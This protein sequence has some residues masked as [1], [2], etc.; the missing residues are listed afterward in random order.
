MVY[1]PYNPPV[2][3]QQV[4][5]LKPRGLYTWPNPLSAVPQGALIEALNIVQRRPSV[6]EQRRGI[7][8][9]GTTLSDVD[10]LYTYQNHI[11][12]HHG[13]TFSYDSDDVGTWL[14]YSGSF[15]PPSNALVNRSFQANQNIYW[16]TSTGVKKLDKLTNSIT[17]SGA[18]AGLD[19]SGTTT[20]SG[21]FANTTQVAYRILFVI[22][23]ANGNRVAGAPTQR[24]IVSNNTGG[25]TNVALTFTVPTGLSTSW[26]YEIYRS[27]MSVDLNTEPNDECALVLTNNL[28]SAELSSLVVT[29]TD[30][31]PDTLK[32]AF[33][34]TAASQEGIAQANYQAPIATDAAYFKGFVFLANLTYQQQLDLT[35]VS[36][37]SLGLQN[38]DTVTIA[39]TVYTGA[40]TEVIASA[41][42]QVFTGGTPSQNITNTAN[43]LVRVINRF[44][45]NSSV[46]AYYQSGYNSLPGQILISERGIGGST[47][48]AASSRPGAFVPDIGTTTATSSSQSAPNEVAICKYLQPESFPIGQTIPVGSK[49]KS[50]LRIIALRDYV[51]VFK[52]DGVFQI[53]G[54]DV[55]SFQ[56]QEVDRTVILQGIE[57]AVALNNKVYLF[58]NQTVISITF[59]EGAI[60]KAQPIKKDLLVLSSP[61]YPAFFTVSYG[62]SYESENEYILGTVTKTTDTTATQYYVYNYLTD[63]WSTWEFPFTMGTGYVNPT[64]NKLYFGSSDMGSQFVY[65]ERKNFDE[66]D[67]ADNSYPVNITGSS[68][69]GTTYTVNLT[70][71]ATTQVGYTLAQS[72]NKAIVLSVVNSTTITVDTNIAWT[73]GA[74][75]VYKPIV[76]ALAFSPE[77]CGNAGLVKQFKEVHSIFSIAD[78]NKFELGFYT[79]FNNTVGTTTLM[80]KSANGWGTGNWGSFP[81]GSG[82]PELQVIRGFVPLQQRRG[83][84]LN[85]TV[86]YAD[87]LTN[88][89]LDGFSIFYQ[90]TSQRFH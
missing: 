22:I 46:Y 19:G 45:G 69:V 25:N 63:N 39:G 33:I 28:T 4:I 67:F 14:P 29:V 8:P 58:S 59:N 55:S 79:D 74:A 50:I 72:T 71:T 89:A 26:T 52:Q 37:G 10:Q 56:E 16:L 23:D 17:F 3:E 61:L 88:F 20:G 18:P 9:Y 41:Q 44:S 85:L 77:P 83:H 53:V 27:P 51:L 38:G 31:I 82:A 24:I 70:S 7:N 81:W 48:T 60:L 66:T 34:Y 13:T 36:V 21:W 30:N 11:I 68:V 57:T 12:A 80:P 54:T 42:F 78:F 5:S 90:N 35:L 62:I 40:S 65:Q 75:T 2:Q 1:K 86:N 76:I 49:D 32:G 47:F 6:I 84:W 15:S 73:N 64:D 43:S 87:A